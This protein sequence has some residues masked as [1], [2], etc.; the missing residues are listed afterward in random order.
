LLLGNS[1]AFSFDFLLM[2][3]NSPG[4]SNPSS[5][6]GNSDGSGGSSPNNDN[7]NNN[8]D[9]NNN[10]NNDSNRVD[11]E[12]VPEPGLI[13]TC[14]HPSYMSGRDLDTPE[15]RANLPCD[16]NPTYQGPNMPLLSHSAFSPQ[17]DPPVMCSR[18]FGIFCHDCVTNLDY[19]SGAS[20]GSSPAPGTT[21]PGTIAPGTTDNNDSS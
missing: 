7:N 3:D 21:A 1:S 9:N 13:A 12:E 4:S 18:C 16:L 14:E 8:E 2:S 5:P 19:D 20:L 11:E 10:D 17:G 6:E 15:N